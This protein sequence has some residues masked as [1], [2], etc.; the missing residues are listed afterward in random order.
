MFFVLIEKDFFASWQ[1]FQLDF[2]A[3]ARADPAPNT[4]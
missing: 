2:C 1:P 4:Y 3:G